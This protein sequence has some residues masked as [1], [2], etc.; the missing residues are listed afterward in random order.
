MCHF[1]NVYS[2][3][4]VR[5]EKQFPWEEKPHG[6]R[7]ELEFGLW[8]CLIVLYLQRSDWKIP[9]PPTPTSYRLLGPKIK[10]RPT[11]FQT[12]TTLIEGSPETPPACLAGTPRRQSN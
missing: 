5:L 6:R 9:Y 12:G 7:L 3:A 2:R 8:S 4:I 1:D 11:A 10:R